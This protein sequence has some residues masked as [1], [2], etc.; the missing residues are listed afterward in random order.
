MQKI[1]KFWVPDIDA[2]PGRNLER[3]KFGFEQRSGVQIWHLHRAL[4]I[5]PGRELA[6]DGGANVGAWTKL[7]AQHFKLVISFEPNPDVYGCLARNVAEWGIKGNVEI[8][9]QAISDQFELVRIETADTGARTVTGKIAGSGD[10]EA[11]T[12]DSLSL[13]SCSFLKFDLEGY[14]AKAIRGA[15]VTINRF[16]PWIL[17]ENKATD[18]EIASGGTQAERILEECGYVL[19]EKIGDDRIDWLYRHNSVN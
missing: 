2:A 18:A 9:R 10:I 6:V 7:M 16:K 17:I 5:V 11:V 1:G 12:I 15:V 3:S 4:E 19:V 14:E 13:A 8:H